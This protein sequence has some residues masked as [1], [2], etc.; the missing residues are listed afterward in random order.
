M[1]DTTF[2]DI[3]IDDAA[4]AE[5]SGATRVLAATD[6]GTDPELVYERK[7]AA[8]LAARL[9]ATLFLSDRSLRTWGET[10]HTRGPATL[11]Q[12]R[13]DGI[14]HMVAQMEEAMALGVGE[15]YAV[16]PSMPSLESVDL[17]VEA[18]DPSVVVVPPRFEETTLGDRVQMRGD[19]VKAVRD[20]AKVVVAHPDGRIT[21]A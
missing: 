12:L 11:E 20:R 4:L 21:L 19:L 17:A 2:D 16:A 5:L 15:V 1:T 6:D 10:P 9:G 14:E 13:A 18:T 3:S 8:R 7:A